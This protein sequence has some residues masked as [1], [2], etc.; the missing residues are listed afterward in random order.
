MLCSIDDDIHNSLSLSKDVKL[1]D[2][3]LI[4]NSTES[5][6]NRKQFKQTSLMSILVYT[7]ISLS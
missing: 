6:T 2:I 4:T 3:A 7:I 1:D 5:Y